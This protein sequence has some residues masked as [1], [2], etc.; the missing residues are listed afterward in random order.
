MEK[1]TKTIRV[2]KDN[3]KIIESIAQENHRTI[4]GE[5][6]YILAKYIQK[7]NARKNKL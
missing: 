4:G 3:W 1:V 5:V 7:Y 6:D 2:L